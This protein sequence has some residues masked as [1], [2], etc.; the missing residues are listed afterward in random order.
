MIA[1]K[2]KNASPFCAHLAYLRNCIL[3]LRPGAKATALESSQ[4]LN[5]RCRK[6][7]LG[8]GTVSWRAIE[9]LQQGLT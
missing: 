3:L 4:S 9:T 6:S 2:K 8:R 5:V 7:P 1:A